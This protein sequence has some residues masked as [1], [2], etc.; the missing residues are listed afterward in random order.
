MGVRRPQWCLAFLVLLLTCSHTPAFAE[1]EPSTPAPFV[2]PQAV[3]EWI[4]QGTTV[5]FLDVREAD[6]FAAGHLPE[7]RNIP[8]DQVMAIAAE[9]PHDQPVV[10][11]CIHSTHRAPEAAKTLRRLGFDN[12]YVMEGGIAA[13]EAGGQTILASDPTQPPKILPFTERCANKPK[14]AS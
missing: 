7:A 10:I 11:Y 3:K 14:P 2:Q 9:L 12:A 13:W 1:D 5:T 8:H 6:E 4:Q